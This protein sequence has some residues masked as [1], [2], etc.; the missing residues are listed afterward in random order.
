[1]KRANIL[2][3]LFVFFEEIIFNILIKVSLNNIILKCLFT[4]Q[5]AILLNILTSLFNKKTNKILNTIMVFVLPIIY[6]T[7]YVY[8]KTFGNFLSIYSLTKGTQVMQFSSGLANIIKNNW[9]EI[10]I[11]IVP[12][13]LYLFFIK[14]IQFDKASI[15]EQIVKISIFILLYMTSILIINLDNESDIYSTKNL[16]Y[17]IVND[18]ENLSNFGLITSVR[19]DIQRAII[20]FK[21]KNLYKYTNTNGETVII[22]AKEYNIININFDELAKNEENEEIKEIHNYI[23]T[24]NPTNKNEYTGIYK[25]KNL[26]VIIAESFSSLA[27]REDLT[28]TLYKL[29]NTCFQFKN[30][31]TPLFPVSTADGEYLTDMSLLPSEGTWSIENVENKTIPYS[32]ANILKKQGYRTY[33]YHNYKYNYY[34]R[35]KYLKTM[36][37]NKYL[38][39][40]NGLEERMD[41][42]LS[43][44]SD[45]DMVK[46]TINDYINDDKFLAYYI[47]MSGHMAYNRNHSIIQKNWNKVKNLQYS[48]EA[49]GYLATQIELDKAVEEIINQLQEKNKLKDTVIVILGDHYPYGLTES[50]IKE[51]SYNKMDDYYFEKFHMPLIIYNEDKSL[52]V[53]VDKYASSLDVLPTLLNLFGVEYD[54][55]LLM[56]QDIF[57][58]NKPLIIFSDRSF[59]TEKGKY[60]NWID[61]FYKFSEDVDKEYIKNKKEEIYL[62]YK[63]SRLILENN[64][65]KVLEQYLP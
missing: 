61:K 40:G 3:I 12:I 26:I 28:P 20:K 9:G 25:D 14:K 58:D 27:I 42:S 59:I 29:A 49:K 50:Q 57:S 4:I 55:R 18:N 56:G 45:Y 51:L 34:S 7:Y 5:F 24:R 48:D 30:F 6:S 21:E 32:Y 35:D 52:N 65:Y 2:I 44:S 39:Q 41:F 1:M 54:S 8:Y 38:A 63:Y 64:Y 62:K 36:G 47:T 16:Y 11:F 46:A 10:L 31:Y 37:Y 33:A 22:D 53:E 17:N 60:N 43:P 23:K 19:L 13:I 15:K